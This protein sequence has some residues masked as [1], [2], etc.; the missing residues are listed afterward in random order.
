[1]DR[2]SLLVS[3]LD[4]TL[5]GDDSA[6]EDFASWYATARDGLRLA[7]SSG[8]FVESVMESLDD[9]RLPLPDAIVG[10]VGTQIYDVNAAEYV[11]GWPTS[12]SD[13]DPY[14][15]QSIGAS[16]RELTLQPAHLNSPHKVS[17]YGHR[18]SEPFLA[19]LRWQLALGGVRAT[20]VYS[21][22]HD[23][24]ILPADANKGAAAIHLARRWNID[25]DQTIVAGDSGNDADMFR[26]GFRG[27]VVGN[28]MPE[29]RELTLPTIYQATNTHAAGVLEGI[30][31]WQCERNGG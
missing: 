31:Y 28:A 8:R 7:Y 22:N 24:D 6:L 29:L 27:I 3:D 5:L 14:V 26:T 2:L 1:M 10:G 15:A 4:G 17:F 18:L 13:W 12:R 23:L 25:L 11:D 16:F 21:S 19:Q 30:R 9:A 20:V